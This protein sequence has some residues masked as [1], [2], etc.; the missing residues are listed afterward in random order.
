MC[1]F[2]VLT[3]PLFLTAVR[4][5]YTKVLTPA[6]SASGFYRNNLSYCVF[7]IFDKT[8]LKPFANIFMKQTKSFST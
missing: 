3:D 1:I 2:N 8:C 6:F 7:V 5:I 4:T